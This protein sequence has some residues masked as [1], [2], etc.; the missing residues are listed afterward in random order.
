MKLLL[1]VTVDFYI[2]QVTIAYDHP[3]VIR[4]YVYNI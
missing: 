3:S 2:Y 4:R 1:D